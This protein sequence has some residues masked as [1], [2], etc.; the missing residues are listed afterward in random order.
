MKFCKNESNSKLF[1]EVIPLNIIKSISKKFLLI[2]FICSIF[3]IKISPIS[4]LDENIN[5]IN[6]IDE[7]ISQTL[8][9]D[10]IDDQELEKRRKLK[11]CDI[12]IKVRLAQ[13][14]VIIT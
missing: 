9:T 3:L 12:L 11:A 1:I 5:K 10:K 7:K 2:S 13:D 6:S 8:K 14:M 4:S